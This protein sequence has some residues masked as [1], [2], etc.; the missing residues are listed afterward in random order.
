MATTTPIEELTAEEAATRLKDILRSE[1]HGLFRNLP[2]GNT[3]R[4]KNINNFDKGLEI[5]GVGRAI[6]ITVCY[7]EYLELVGKYNRTTWG[8]FIIFVEKVRPLREIPVP[9]GWHY[10]P[11]GIKGPCPHCGCPAKGLVN[12][13][14]RKVDDTWERTASEGRQL[15]FRRLGAMGW[16]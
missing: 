5:V 4:D 9:D 2:P 6:T 1:W 7:S 14:H 12:I 13:Y 15:V 11:K 3:Y 8:D 10:K 16:E